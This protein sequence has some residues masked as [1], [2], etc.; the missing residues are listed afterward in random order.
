MSVVNA[1]AYRSRA[2]ELEPGT[3][4]WGQTLEEDHRWGILVQWVWDP[5]H[6]FL[7]GG[8]REMVDQQVEVETLACCD[9]D[10]SYRASS[11]LDL[12]IR[13]GRAA[14]Y[15]YP[16]LHVCPFLEAALSVALVMLAAR[17]VLEAVAV[18]SGVWSG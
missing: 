8:I 11:T 18:R 17:R 13:S 2:D 10:P 7:E 6:A 4:A 3:L 1:W 14:Y 12:E 16:F 5:V 15:P 9:L